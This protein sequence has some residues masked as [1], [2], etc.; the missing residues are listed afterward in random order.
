MAIAG[1][2]EIQLLANIARL[3]KDMDDAKRSV[4]GAMATIEKTVG[5][6]VRAM[7]L[8][9]GALSIGAFV[10]MAKQ[11]IDTADAINKLTQRTGLAAETLSQLQY[12]AKLADVSSDSLTTGIKKLN[13]SIAGGLAGDKEKL[14]VFKSLGITLTDTAGRTKTAD[15][16]LLEMADTFAKS[17]DGAGKTAA[18][19]DLLGKAGD[20]MIPLLNGGSQA[21]L[22]MMKEADRLGLT[23]SGDFAARAEEFNDNLTRIQT[24][25]E[26]LAISLGGDLVDGLGKAMKAMADAVAEGNKL[27]GVVNFIQTLITGDDQYKAQVKVVTETEKLM[28]AQSAL[29]RAR[30][31]NNEKEIARLENAVR[32]RQAELDMHRNYLGMLDA[33]EKKSKDAAAAA[34]K[35]RTSGKEIRTESAVKAV[36]G[37]TEAEKELAEQRKRDLAV[38][39][40]RNKLTEENAKQEARALADL[41][42]M[43][44][45]YAEANAKGVAES[46]AAANQAEAELAAYGLLKSAV[47]ELTLAHLEQ[48]K[49]LAALAG[50]DVTN[51]EKRIEAQKRLITATR[52]MEVLDANKQAAEDAAR[53]WQR[54]SEQIG[55]SLTDALM[56]G[57]KS[58]ADYI[59][60]LFRTLVLRPLLSP[61][62]SAGASVIGSLPGAGGG[63][64]LLG[65]VGQMAGMANFGGMSLANSAGSMF[66]NATGGGLDALLATNGAFGTAAGGAGIMGTLS[67]ALPWVGGALAIASM[68]ES[69]RGGPKSIGGTSD[70]A[71]I[72]STV[73][74]TLASFGIRNTGMRVG[75]FS[76]ADPQGDSL[77]QL[78]TALFQ[79]DRALYSRQDRVGNYENVGRSSE[80]LAAAWAEEQSRIMLAALQAT[81]EPKYQQYIS[82]V[83]ADASDLDAINAALA[84]LN[85]AR[86]LEEQLL[87][88]SSTDAENM[89]RAR[90]RELDAMD[91]A[92]RP[93]QERLNALQDE[94][95][96]TGKITAVMG[97]YLSDTELRAARI[98]QIHQQLAKAGLEISLERIASATR[99]DLR[100]LYEE[101]VRVG[102][103]GAAEALLDVAGAFAQITDPANEAATAIEDMAQRLQDA[104]RGVWDYVRTLTATRAGT[105][106]P[107]DLLSNTRSNY[108][109][110]LSLSRAG[111]LDAYGRI[112]SS[113]QAYIDAQKGFTASGG[114]TQAVI[115]QII[116]E[117][118]SLPAVQSYEQQNLALLGQ[119]AQATGSTSTSTGGNK[120]TS[121]QILSRLMQDSLLSYSRAEAA[122]VYNAIANNTGTS[123][124]YLSNI[125]YHSQLMAN[126][127]IN[128]VTSVR[129]EFRGGGLATFETG[130]FHSGGLR[131]VGEGGPELE[132]TGPSRIF[133]AQQTRSMLSGSGGASSEE[134]RGLR[135]DVR[136]LTAVVAAGMDQ[137]IA[138]QRTIAG[139]TK[140]SA[141]ESLL[142]KARA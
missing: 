114:D 80:E 127:L 23:I 13:Q 31:S 95:R 116:S 88:L 111:D 87:T 135:E 85:A 60:D 22:E 21:I 78:Q 122:A 36:K 24:Q 113:A 11:A 77:T 50:E 82:D 14:S 100:A 49:E 4:G 68:L 32:L 48:S 133:N 124:S 136:R 107:M 70:A 5:G 132:V 8:L 2:L 97:D 108:L 54:A 18:A 10:S 12:A 34:A 138:T 43:M 73:A 46:V 67:A 52:G 91:A 41:A 109:Q 84:R 7:G 102:D 15:Q 19:I 61:I 128:G 72:Q 53:E 37:L 51:I 134:I 139:N 45:E 92:L 44:D 79:G 74:A 29:D 56:S 30:G 94:A 137:S 123:A 86:T 125:A 1:V 105:A 126:Q 3:Q 142:K 39:E 131:L 28:A 110:D 104:G 26:K 117:L 76:A 57:G 130:G 66:A 106:S 103:M 120:V 93:L 112:N 16:V 33:E 17:R 27:A 83:N 141:D 42:K 38:G 71:S 101:M 69:P 47:L 63:S 65:Q 140:V 59:R 6:A 62:G 9:G 81:L 121:D 58:G 55:Q 20:E 90:Q 129:S 75:G 99:N 115:G 40:L 96:I 98:W 89:A 118:N 64:G 119:I 35:I 25:S